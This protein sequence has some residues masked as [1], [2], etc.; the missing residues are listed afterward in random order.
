[1]RKRDCVKRKT[2]KQSGQEKGLGFRVA[3][4]KGVRAYGGLL[5]L[6]AMIGGRAAS[7]ILAYLI[8]I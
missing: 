7:L 4:T 8:Y 2:S 1:M 5:V 6:S 3:R